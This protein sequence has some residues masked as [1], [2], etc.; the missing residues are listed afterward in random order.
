MGLDSKNRYYA[1][2]EPITKADVA[3]ASRT[4]TGNSTA[5][6]AEGERELLA[7]LTIGAVS[8]TTPTLDIDLEE[9]V[10]ATNWHVVASFP[11]KTDADASSTDAKAFAGLGKQCRWKWTI[12]GG[13]ADF[14]FGITV[15]ARR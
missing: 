4:V 9:S 10:D 15:E 5:F 3:S 11:Q 7:T 1:D 14:T 12:T 13:S 2:P 6:T 8:G